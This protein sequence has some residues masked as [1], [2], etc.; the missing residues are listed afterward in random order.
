M[1]LLKDKIE[2]KLQAQFSPIHLLVVNES[3]LHKGHAG[4]DGSGESHYAVEIVSSQ[5]DNKSRLAAQRMVL[6]VLA[7]EIAALH[8]LSISARAKK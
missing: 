6:A 2:N 5:F 1:V 7:D 8:A 3:H 4:D